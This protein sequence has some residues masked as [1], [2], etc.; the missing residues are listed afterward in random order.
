MSDWQLLQLPQL[1]FIV[2]NIVFTALLEFSIGNDCCAVTSIALYVT[3][4]CRAYSFFC[5]RAASDAKVLDDP[6]NFHCCTTTSCLEESAPVQ[7]FSVI[8]CS[9]GFFR[10]L[11]T[12]FAARSKPPSR[13]NYPKASY[14]ITHQRDQDAG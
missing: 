10:L 4:C 7:K 12:E 1:T 6:Q 14:P 9:C 11:S 5:C 2:K 13:D 8:Q 3:C